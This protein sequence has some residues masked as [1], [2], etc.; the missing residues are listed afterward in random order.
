M[1]FVIV[2][3]LCVRYGVCVW[4]IDIIDVGFYDAFEK[5]EVFERGGYFE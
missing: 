2:L 4:E 3:G 5:D 1:V